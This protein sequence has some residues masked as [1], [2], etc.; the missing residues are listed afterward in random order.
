MTIRYREAKPS[1]ENVIRSDSVPG[2]N[3]GTLQVRVAVF[4]SRSKEVTFVGLKLIVEQALR[5]VA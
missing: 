4:G 3:A 1:V 2:V 5:V